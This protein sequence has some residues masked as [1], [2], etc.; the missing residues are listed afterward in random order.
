MRMLLI[1]DGKMGRAIA[2]IAAERGDEVVAVLGATAN[3]GARAISGFSGSVDV[4]IEFTEPSAAAPNVSACIR[5]GIPVVCGT[6][7]WQDA[8]QVVAE[9][10][11]AKNGALLV[12]SNF[13]IG[14]ALVTEL[15]ER[16]GE[17]FRAFPQYGAA[18]VETHH[19][20]K[21][22]APSGTAITIATAAQ[23][24]LGRDIPA[25]SVRVGSAPGTHTLLFDGPFE[26]IS[27][28]HE[29][30]DRRVFADGAWRAAHWLAGRR[31]V[32]TMRDVLSSDA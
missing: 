5:A 13:S 32:F 25:S 9:E 19:A 11:R 16:A 20:A 4:A 31:G 22:D 26:Q 24:G 14:V 10:A 6:T 2:A 15:A 12:A 8:Q 7:G 23:R 3:E 1:G 18:I 17:L 21:K 30:R 29:A 28:T 27:L